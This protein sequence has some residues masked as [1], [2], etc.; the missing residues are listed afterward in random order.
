MSIQ[1][2][3]WVILRPPDKPSFFANRCSMVESANGGSCQKLTVGHP[4]LNDGFV[5]KIGHVEG[6]T[7]MGIYRWPD[8][9]SHLEQRLGASRKAIADPRS[10]KVVKHDYGLRYRQVDKPV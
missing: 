2:R 4:V 9:A 6:N 3:N 10:A 5:P 1:P 8:R 7:M